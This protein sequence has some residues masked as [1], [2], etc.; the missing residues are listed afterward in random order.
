MNTM[1]RYFLFAGLVL[2]CL[3]W[4]PAIAGELL[5]RWKTDAVDA[6]ITRLFVSDAAEALAVLQLDP[7][8]E[9][10]EYNAVRWLASLSNDPLV[11][12]QYHLHQANDA[13]I[14]AGKAWKKTT[15]SAKV[16]VAVI[17]TGID[18]D[19]PDLADNIWTNPTE[20]ANNGLDD[21]A[22]GYIDDVQGWDFVENDNDPNPTPSLSGWNDTVVVHGTHV[23]GL[24]GAVGNNALGVSGVNWTVQ[25]M[26]L[27][28]FNDSGSGTAADILAAIAYAQANDADILNMSYGGHIYSAFEEEAVADAYSNGIISVAAAG[29]A[30]VDLNTSPSYPICYDQV[31]G[32]TATD[33]T[34]VAA[35]FTN[36]G[37][38]C[39]DVAAP[40]D[41]IL[42]TY[43]T[44]DILHGFS[45]DYGYLSGT[46]MSTP[47]VSGVAALILSVN[48]KFGPAD[49]F[50]IIRSSSDKIGNA[51][52]GHGRVNANQAL[53]L[54]QARNVP[55]TPT[56]KGYHTTAKQKRLTSNQRTKDPQV[57]FTWS[58]P[59][60][61]KAI[62]GYYVYFGKARRDPV[63]AGKLYSKRTLAVPVIHGND[64]VYRLRVKAVDKAGQVSGLA[65]FLYRIDTYVQRPTWNYLT[66]TS[67]GDVELHWHQVAG[68]NVVGYAIYRAVNDATHY[69]KIITTTVNHKSYTDTTVAPGHT[70][71]YKVRSIDDLGNVSSLSASQTITL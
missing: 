45:D 37:N 33:A 44:D 46:S 54:A 61:T 40:G 68:D 2:W 18:L 57:V 66:V 62:T 41:T 8:V 20:V 11:T 12:D 35:S 63:K 65:Q 21:D 22:N 32:V 1:D 30:A 34:D 70:Y 24:I 55:S 64:Q 31:I 47:I 15:G 38:T 69:R 36:Y 4:N 10:V 71:G 53:R 43:Y 49:V 42:S 67:T 17:D 59:A 39:A 3:P 5:V 58:E 14:D 28:I 19:H 27:R 9:H 13:D 60:L 16:V 50:D 7:R 6:P 51:T 56:I 25:L 26:P 52:L 23:A 48:K 29:N